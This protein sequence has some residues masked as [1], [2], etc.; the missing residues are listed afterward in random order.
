MC[1]PPFVFL[2]QDGAVESGSLLLD[3]R[4]C[5]ARVDRG[6]FVEIG[7]PSREAAFDRAA[8]LLRLACRGLGPVSI[9]ALLATPTGAFSLTSAGGR[10][11]WTTIIGADVALSPTP[12]DPYVPAPGA[13]GPLVV[14]QGGR[15]Q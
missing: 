4:G 6:C 12:I 15:G 5:T 9:M 11:D 8:E 7:G 3:A 13:E 2:L 10:D 14:L 1:P